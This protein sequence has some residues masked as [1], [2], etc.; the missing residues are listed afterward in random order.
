MSKRCLVCKQPFDPEPD[1][2]PH[3]TTFYDGT[4]IE[5]WACPTCVPDPTADAARVAMEIELD[6]AKKAML[7][8]G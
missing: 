6:R 1:R 3:I 5:W 2:R 7:G 4:P 8:N